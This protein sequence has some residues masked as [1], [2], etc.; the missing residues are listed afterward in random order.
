MGETKASGA[1]MESW[2]KEIGAVTLFV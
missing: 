1:D 2:P